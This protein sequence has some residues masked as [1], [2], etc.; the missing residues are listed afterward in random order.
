MAYIPA[1]LIAAGIAVL[2][3]MEMP[4]SEAPFPHSDK[5]VHGVMYLMLSVALMV[6]V[7][8]QWASRVIPY[9]CVCVGSVAYG[10]LIEVLQQFCTRSRSG[11]ITDLLAD[12]AGALIGV[13]LVYGITK[14]TNHKS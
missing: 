11:E 3:L 14:I 13:L 2:C 8:R 5:V 10:G 9:V 4:P 6:P 1:V 12:A 7:S